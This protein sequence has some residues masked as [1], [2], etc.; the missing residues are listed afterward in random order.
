MADP[1]TIRIF[2]ANGDPEGVRIIDRMNWTGLGI[3]FPRDKWLETRS[4]SEFDRTGVYILVGY[5]GKEDD[6]LPTL[7]IGQS[8]GVRNRINSHYEDKDFWNWGIV[9]VSA[10]NGLNRA[11]VTWLEYALVQRALQAKRSHLDNGNRPQEPVLS[12]SEKADTQGFLKEIMQILPIVGL[13]AFE[14]PKAVAIPKASS[15]DITELPTIVQNDTLLPV[16]VEKDTVIVPAQ[17]EGFER[18]FLGEHCW[19]AIRISGGMLQK[20]K[21]IAA[22][23]TSPVSAITHYAPVDRIEPYG[24]EGKY[25]LIFSEKAKKIDPIPFG[26][27]SKGAMQSP[28]YTSF[29]SLQSAKKLADLM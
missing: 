26:D 22:Y 28:R 23:Q 8:D 2:V 1:F 10:N 11:H 9:F 13:Q 29:T 20:I 16:I 6:E 15:N 14:F 12:E 4:R 19:Y 5:E 21:Y 24:E 17:K 3:A 7:Y 27:A 18:V 25:K